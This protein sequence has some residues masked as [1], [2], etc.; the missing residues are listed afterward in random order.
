MFYDSQNEI[1]SQ[2]TAKKGADLVESEENAEE[3]ADVQGHEKVVANEA[4]AGNLS[5]DISRPTLIQIK[6]F[7]VEEPKVVKKRISKTPA[8]L[9][10]TG[11]RNLQKL[12]QK[13]FMKNR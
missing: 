9:A 5:E 3:K 13:A 1:E 12:V 8:G 7:D 4:G 6:M 2:Q 11:N 10:A